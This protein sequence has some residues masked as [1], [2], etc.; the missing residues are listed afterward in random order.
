MRILCVNIL[1]RLCTQFLPNL[2][3][4]VMRS[5]TYPQSACT[6]PRSDFD[7]PV[8]IAYLLFVSIV[9]CVYQHRNRFMCGSDTNYHATTQM[10]QVWPHLDHDIDTPPYWMP[11]VWNIGTT[12]TCHPN[13]MG[14]RLHWFDGNVGVAGRDVH[15]RHLLP[16]ER[17]NPQPERLDRGWN[18]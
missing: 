16:V 8:T 7:N 13:C 2:H 17:A 3:T 11:V 12:I 4:Q 5:Q 1:L 6:Q 14:P 15:G 9:C 10:P 18:L